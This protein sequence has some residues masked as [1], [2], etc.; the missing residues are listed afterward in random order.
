KDSRNSIPFWVIPAGDRACWLIWSTPKHLEA[1]S[2]RQNTGTCSSGCERRGRPPASL[3]SRS[4]RRS[5]VTNPSSRNANS[6]SAVSIR[7]IS[8]GS[9]SC[10][11]N[12]YRFS[13]RRSRLRARR[14]ARRRLR[15]QFGLA[16]CTGHNSIHRVRTAVDAANN[17]PDTSS[18]VCLLGRQSVL[19]STRRET[20][21]LDDLGGAVVVSGETWC[22][23]CGFPTRSIRRLSPHAAFWPPGDPFGWSY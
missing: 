14:H 22:K 12:R 1:Q 15:A 9:P 4:P 20:A 19:E 21:P 2:T 16:G 3:R 6:A 23:S 18:V 8:L 11:E 7:L 10:T 5:V 13:S 17:N